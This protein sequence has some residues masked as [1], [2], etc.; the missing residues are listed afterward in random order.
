MSQSTIFADTGNGATITYA[1]TSWAVKV[2][3]LAL[4]AHMRE[5]LDA[6]TLDTTGFE[7]TIQGDLTKRPVLKCKALFDTF[8]N[9]PSLTSTPETVTITF[10][11]RTGETTAASYAGT[12]FFQNIQM[13]TLANAQVQEVDFD[14]VFDG[15]TGPTFT[16]SA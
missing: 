2:K 14:I 6:S 12:G 3:S 7:K 11:T 4:P 5:P 13:P 9:I 10:P 16:K 15:G 1:T 8:L